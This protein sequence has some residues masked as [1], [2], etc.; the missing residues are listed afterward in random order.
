MNMNWSSYTHSGRTKAILLLVLILV[1]FSVG[2]FLSGRSKT[3]VDGVPLPGDSAS[4]AVRDAASGNY[5][6]EALKA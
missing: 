3:G 5:Q 1:S 2:F 6:K 4:L